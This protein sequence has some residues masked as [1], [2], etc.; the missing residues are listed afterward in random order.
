[1]ALRHTCGNGDHT[2]GKDSCAWPPYEQ[3]MFGW[4]SIVAIELPT[5]SVGTSYCPAVTRQRADWLWDNGS[6]FGRTSDH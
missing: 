4:V 1:M 3:N 5:L 6:M 2:K